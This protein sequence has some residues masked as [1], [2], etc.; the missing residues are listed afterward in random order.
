MPTENTTISTAGL[1]VNMVL[2]ELE[3]P[4]APC[5]VQW[6]VTNTTNDKKWGQVIR[7]S[8]YCTEWLAIA[9]GRLE[10]RRCD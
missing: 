6:S 10:T 1:D 4:F 7:A 2:A 8:D 5:Q 3:V 9:P